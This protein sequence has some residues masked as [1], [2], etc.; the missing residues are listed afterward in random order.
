ME[1]GQVVPAHQ[2]DGPGG[3]GARVRERGPVQLRPLDDPD[4]RQP[5]NPRPVTAR[6]G[7]EQHCYPLA[8]VD[9]ELFHYPVGQHV[10]PADDQVIPVLGESAGHRGHGE[11]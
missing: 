4:P 6:P 7:T 2:G 8:V 3:P 9:G 1:V 11:I 10:V 5:G